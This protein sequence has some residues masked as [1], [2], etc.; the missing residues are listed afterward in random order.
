MKK[1]YLLLAVFLILTMVFSIS[2]DVFAA[3]KVKPI[4]AQL[5]EA[6]YNNLA[7]PVVITDDVELFY[8]KQWIDIDA[9]GVYDGS[10]IFLVKDSSNA[11]IPLTV[12]ADMSDAHPDEYLGQ[13]DPPDGTP[14]YYVEYILYGNEIDGYYTADLINNETR[15]TVP[16]G[17]VDTTTPVLMTDWLPTYGPWFPQATAFTTEALAIIPVVNTPLSLLDNLYWQTEYVENY[18]NTWQAD[19]VRADSLVKIDFVDWGNP[20]ETTNPLVGYRFPVELYLYTKL[21]DDGLMTAYKMACLDYPS[22]AEEVYGTNQAAY[23]SYYATV[24]TNKFRVEVFDGDNYYDIDIEPAIGPSG[25]MNFA[26]AGGGWVPQ[27][28]GKHRI[29]FYLNDP[30][31]TL[32]GA[33]VNNDEHYV[34]SHG[35]MAE[36]LSDNRQEVSYINGQYVT[37]IDVDVVIPNSNGGRKT[38]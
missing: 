33:I 15:E 1:T 36:E 7:T 14:E 21:P 23:E 12:A 8:T 11:L 32:E 38:R 10:E 17:L 27:K 26:S 22:S 37:W 5:L 25:K 4:A 28:A 31:I 6:P 19:W 34:F 20:L 35:I 30:N 16:D 13:V 18:K 9:D 3:K 2:G 29:T 24:L